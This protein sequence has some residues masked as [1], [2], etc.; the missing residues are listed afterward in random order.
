MSLNSHEK[1]FFQKG[2]S[3]KSILSILIS[4]DEKVLSESLELTNP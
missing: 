1:I 2:F 4:V 3:R